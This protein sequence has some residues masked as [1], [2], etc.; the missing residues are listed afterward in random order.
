MCVYIIYI[1]ICGGLT[2]SVLYTM[3]VTIGYAQGWLGGPQWLLLCTHRPRDM[4]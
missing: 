1:Y 4:V 2:Y 3:W